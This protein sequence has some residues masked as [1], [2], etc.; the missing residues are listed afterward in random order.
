MDLCWNTIMRTTQNLWE[1]ACQL[2]HGFVLEHDYVYDT[3]TCGSWL[4]SD[5]VIPDT[6]ETS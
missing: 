6:A 4:A 1:L 5:G 2:A 3:K